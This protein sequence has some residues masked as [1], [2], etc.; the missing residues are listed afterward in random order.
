MPVVEVH[1]VTPD[2][3]DP[4]VD[5]AVD[6]VPLVVEPVVV[7]VPAVAVPPV[8]APVVDPIVAELLV[9]DHV[10][11]AVVPVVVAEI[12]SSS[13][14]IL[15]LRSS[16]QFHPKY[17][18]TSNSPSMTKIASQV[19]FFIKNSE[20]IKYFCGYELAY[21]VYQ[22]PKKFYYCSPL[23]FFSYIFMRHFIG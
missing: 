2:V 5:P 23:L 4:V 18:T 10:V 16:H 15:S 17:K 22:D 14:I 9:V 7:G 6:E 8:T 3:T 13:S 12:E 11:A 21:F 19:L 20:E 1:V